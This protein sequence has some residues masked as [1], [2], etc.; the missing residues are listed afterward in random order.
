MN[1]EYQDLFIHELD[2]YYMNTFGVDIADVDTMEEIIL[3]LN[4]R[5][6]TFP[7]YVINDM[8]PQPNEPDYDINEANRVRNDITNMIR[9]YL[10]ER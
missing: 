8:L 7:E 10:M 2:H 1:N 3:I 9:P 5:P 4:T 6:H